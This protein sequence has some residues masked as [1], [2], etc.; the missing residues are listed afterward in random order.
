MFFLKIQTK[1]VL[2][3]TTFLP[4]FVYLLVPN[5]SNAA[6]YDELAKIEK[7]CESSPH[8]CLLLLD[9]ALAS[10]TVKSRQWYRLKLI[11]LDAL[12]TLQHFDKLSLEIE[13]LLSYNTLPINF[14][15]Y[16]YIY[17]AKLSYGN[18]DIKPTRD[19][20]D[21]AVSLLTQIND[22]YQDPIRLIEISNLQIAMKEY[23]KAKITLLQLD[24]KF[25]KRYHPIFKRELYANLGHV[26]Y[27]QDDKPLHIK[28]RKDSLKWAKAAKNKQQIGVAYNNV[29]LAYKKAGEYKNAEESY[30]RAIN[31]AEG[32]KDVINGSI[33]K[34]KLIEVIFL[35]GNVDKALMIFNKVPSNVEGI[36]ESAEYNKLY[37]NLILTLDQ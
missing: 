29:A 28:Y 10:S 34:L 19:Y 14:S 7:T 4:L 18:K 35:Q 9:D 31:L 2:F 33:S 15:I 25:K 1:Q 32:E 13:T 6:T 23:E 27:F 36:N 8:Q 11:Q 3:L 24:Q 26:A 16:V 30:I 5:Y 22:K 20:L 12:F 37:K 17:Y 21:K